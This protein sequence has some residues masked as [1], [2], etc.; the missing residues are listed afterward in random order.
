MTSVVEGPDWTDVP[1]G[2]RLVEIRDPL[3]FQ[4]L[5]LEV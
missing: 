1:D 5:G 4:L 2:A 3:T